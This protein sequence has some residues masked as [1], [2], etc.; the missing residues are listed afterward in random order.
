VKGFSVTLLTKLVEIRSNFD[1]DNDAADIFVCVECQDSH[2]HTVTPD[3][4]TKEGDCEFAD[5]K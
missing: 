2:E 4:E 1:G 5:H 3:A